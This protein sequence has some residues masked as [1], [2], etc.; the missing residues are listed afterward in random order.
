MIDAGERRAA[1]VRAAAIGELGAAGIAPEYLEL[2]APRTLAPVT[3]IDDD[4]LAVV[5]AKV[6]DTRLID[7]ELL[8]VP[9]ATGLTPGNKNGRT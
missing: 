4:V 9:V 7:N 2:V 3:E 6:G 1:E 5:A 8:R